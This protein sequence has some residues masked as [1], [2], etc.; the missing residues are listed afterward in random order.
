M[1]KSTSTVTPPGVFP[2][3]IGETPDFTH[4]YVRTGGIVP[5]TCVFLLL[6][7]VFLALRLYTR[8]RIIQKPGWD[9]VVV[10]LAWLC[11]IS[12]AGIFNRAFQ[13]GFGAHIWNMTLQHFSEYSKVP[14]LLLADYEITNRAL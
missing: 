4:P 2:A 5:L 6:S 9:D 10:T 11:V 8:I 13:I 14:I 12:I 3:P 7:S 1:P